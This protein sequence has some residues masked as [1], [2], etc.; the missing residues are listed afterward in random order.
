MLG[1]TPSRGTRLLRAYLREVAHADIEKFADFRY[2][3]VV[4]EGLIR[5]L[6]RTVACE[7]NFSTIAADLAT[8]A[9]GIRSETV[10]R[11]INL[12][13]RLFVV[14]RQS[15]WAPALRSKARLRSSPKWH[16]ADPS[17]AVAALG[18]D[19]AQLLAEPKTVGF[20]F[21]SAVVH[22][23]T[24]LGSALEAQV[25]HYRDS[26][27][28]EIDIVLVLPN[29]KWGAVEVKLGETQIAEGARTLNLAVSRIDSSPTFRL[30]ITATGGTYVLDDGT[31]T[32]PLS[33]LRP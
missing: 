10:A 29:G 11:Y 9:P 7:V 6:A 5:S 3:P 19:E 25:H 31:I 4:I 26:N 24:I 17:L 30:V 22:D 33:A 16:F 1:I 32:C 18:A 15:A 14:E 8:I 20:L 13:E 2:D 21:E 23:L 28:Q 27:G 12:L